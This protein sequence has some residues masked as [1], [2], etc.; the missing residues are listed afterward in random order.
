MAAED[1]AERFRLTANKSVLEAAEEEYQ[2]RECEV[3]KS[4]YCYS[5][6]E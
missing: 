6:Q 1:E 3:L 2:L 5:T 4:S